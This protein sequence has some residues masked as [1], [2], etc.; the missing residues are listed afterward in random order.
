MSFNHI[1]VS[2]YGQYNPLMPEPQRSI[3]SFMVFAI[4]VEGSSYDVT[5]VVSDSIEWRY[6]DAPRKPR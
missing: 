5:D 3:R 4:G 1:A 2:K 6:Y